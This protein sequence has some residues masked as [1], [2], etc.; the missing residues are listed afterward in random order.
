MPAGQFWGIHVAAILGAGLV[1]L[2]VK[3]VFGK[4]FQPQAA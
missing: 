2:V 1:F 3:L 4:M